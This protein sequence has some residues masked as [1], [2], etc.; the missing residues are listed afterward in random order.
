MHSRQMQVLGTH[1]EKLNDVYLVCIKT[2]L[3]LF[4]YVTM[5]AGLIIF[6]SPWWFHI[7]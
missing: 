5:E 2:L 4:T 7:Q 1:N 6:K 3:L